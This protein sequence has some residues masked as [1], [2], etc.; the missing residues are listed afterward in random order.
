MA[1]E[2]KCLV[3]SD[4]ISLVWMVEKIFSF[5]N[6]TCGHVSAKVS[7]PPNALHIAS[8]LCAHLPG[9][10]AALT[11][12]LSIQ[13][14]STP[15][16]CNLLPCRIKYTGP[17]EATVKHWSVVEGEDGTT[18]FLRLGLYAD[19]FVCRHKDS[20]LSR[21]KIGWKIYFGAWR[22]SG[23]YYYLPPFSLNC[24]TSMNR[25]CPRSY[26]QETGLTKQSGDIQ[27]RGPSKRFQRV[28]DFR[29]D[30]NLGP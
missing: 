26:K 7:R 12:M 29:R 30:H 25:P 4:A 6:N 2:N 24:L 15:A 16:R 20:I 27:G 9:I 17:T 13:T 11:N 1:V 10:S 21:E 5:S 23:Y 14:S 18:Q 22:L 28:I 8:T 19:Y 3:P